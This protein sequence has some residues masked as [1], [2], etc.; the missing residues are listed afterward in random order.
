MGW[1]LIVA[2]LTISWFGLMGL[3]MFDMP[4]EKVSMGDAASHVS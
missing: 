2:G 3:A 1:E 4:H